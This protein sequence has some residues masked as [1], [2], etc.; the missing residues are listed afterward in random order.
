LTDSDV[1]IHVVDASG[2]ADTEGNDVGVDGKSAGLSHPL[3]DLSWIRNE[4]VE[5]VYANVMHKW[6]NIRRRGKSKVS[7]CFRSTRLQP[8][9]AN[10]EMRLA[11]RHV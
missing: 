4:L 6:D 2:T 8:I 5:W 10:N 3:S 7:N 9:I 1:L 11:F